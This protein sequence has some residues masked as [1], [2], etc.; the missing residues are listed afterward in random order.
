MRESDGCALAASSA[1]SGLIGE[2]WMLA[3]GFQRE[4]RK[5]GEI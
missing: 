4:L 2:S 1:T 3:K 5:G